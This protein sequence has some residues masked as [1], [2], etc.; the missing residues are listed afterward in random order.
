VTDADR[1]Q[2]LRRAVRDWPGPWTTRRTQHL[3]QAAYGRG[4]WRRTARRDLDQLA[5]QGLL[6]EHGPE[7]NR[8]FTFNTW[9]GA[10][11]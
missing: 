10:T 11:S 1:L 2:L 9:T 6:T 5:R 7:N 3:Y 4:D 8:H